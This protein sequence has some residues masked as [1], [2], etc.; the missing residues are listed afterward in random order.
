[1]GNSYSGNSDFASWLL[2]GPLRA[3]NQ[4]VG[5]ELSLPVSRGF[6]VGQQR[7]GYGSVEVGYRDYLGPASDE[8]RLSGEV[9]VDVA[10][11]QSNSDPILRYLS[12]ASA[13]D[14]FTRIAVSY[15]GAPMSVQPWLWEVIKYQWRGSELKPIWYS[16]LVLKSKVRFRS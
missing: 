3:G 12:L 5:V 16:F 13:E 1:L 7:Y 4:V 6:Q 15:V 2:T 10:K 14:D 8:L 11:P 9:S